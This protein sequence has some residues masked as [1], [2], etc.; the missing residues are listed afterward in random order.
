MKAFGL[1][2]KPSKFGYKLTRE[3]YFCPTPLTH[4]FY[5][6][7]ELKDHYNDCMLNFDLN[8]NFYKNL[9][10]EEF[11]NQL[12]AFLKKN[13]GFEEVKDLNKYKNDIGTYM[14]VLDDYC[15]VYIGTTDNFIKRIR[16]HMVE[17]KPVDELISPFEGVFYSRWSRDSFRV[18]DVTRI[19][20][21]PSGE[22]FDE[23]QYI[24]Q[25]SNDFITN[26]TIGGFLENGFYDAIT[27]IK[28]RNLLKFGKCL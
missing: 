17:N 20:I 11:N 3:N 4:Q 26:R 24:K 9:D 12:N 8:M 5:N 27:N 15:Q 18:L 19:Y 1:E 28:K 6:K 10:R 2:F 7:K 16:K 21:Y 13:S 23:Q 14:M 22:K 25:F